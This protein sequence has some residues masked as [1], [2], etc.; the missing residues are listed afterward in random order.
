MMRTIQT[1]YRY[2]LQPTS[3]QLSF[4]RQFAGARRWIWNWALARRIEHF[5]TTG[6]HLSL[7]TL[8]AELTRIKQQPETAWLRTIDSQALQQAL[9]DLD[10]AYQH[11]FRRVKQKARR[12]GFPKFKSK[13]H[14]TPRFRIPQRVTLSGR[15]VQ[16][17][18]IGAIKAVIHRPL[19][20]TTKSATFT[21]EPDGAWYI[22]FV[23]EQQVPVSPPRA[24]RTHV[25]VDLGLKSLVTL[26]SGETVENPRWYRTQMKKLRRAQQALSRRQKGS[27]N[28]AKARRKVAH[29]HAKVRRQRQDFLHKL[30]ARLV[31]DYDLVTI[32]DLNIRGL[33]RTKLSTSVI[34]AGWG[35]FRLY[36]TYKAERSNATLMLVDRFFA[37][38]RL[39]PACGTVNPDLTLADR[40]WTCP[41]GITHD[42]DLNAARNIDREGLRLYRLNVAAGSAETQNVCGETVRPV[43]TI[44]AS[45]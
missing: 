10:Q 19:D 9:R 29:Q 8:F 28:R 43:V 34:D 41:C 2:R 3:T 17:P 14:D 24:V 39:C 11:F 4:L 13:H 35:L 27:A 45:R 20:G 16:V 38:T 42:R 7:T 32:E 21:Q 12:K 1:T 31:R 40:N 18:K 6:Q 37:S 26:S 25:G 44:G 33:A 23:V 5:K 22:S 30:S 15:L 36:L